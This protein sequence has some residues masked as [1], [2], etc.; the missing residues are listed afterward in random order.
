LVEV[1]LD[2]LSKA[3]PLSPSLALTRRYRWLNCPVALPC[4]F[5]L[6]VVGHLSWLATSRVGYHLGES[7]RVLS[8]SR[9][10]SL[11]SPVSGWLAAA[12]ARWRESTVEG[13]LRLDRKR[14]ICRRI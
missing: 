12:L 8:G 6:A 9:A 2:S 7:N 4:R 14:L 1:D 10:I 3:H 11:K 13:K 5:A